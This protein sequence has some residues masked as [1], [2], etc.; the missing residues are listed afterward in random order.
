MA[1]K[2]LLVFVVFSSFMIY[3]EE[4]VQK[5]EVSFEQRQCIEDEYLAELLKTGK[6]AKE[7]LDRIKKTEL[8]ANK[9]ET[10]ILFNEALIDACSHNPKAIEELTKKNKDQCEQDTQRKKNQINNAKSG[11]IG[12]ENI[13]SESLS[14]CFLQY[15][16]ECKK[17]TDEIND[18]LKKIFDERRAIL[19]SKVMPTFKDQIVKRA[20]TLEET[21]L[22]GFERCKCY[23]KDRER[24]SACLSEDNIILS[25]ISKDDFFDKF[26]YVVFKRVIEAVQNEGIPLSEEQII[27]ICQQRI[28][29][30]EGRNYSMNDLEATKKKVVAA[31]HD[32]LNPNDEAKPSILNENEN[33]ENEEL[34][35][36]L[37]NNESEAENQD[38]ILAEVPIER[39]CS[40]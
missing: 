9:N 27:K 19:E 7:R 34:K 32:L 29:H 31:L 2:L 22:P 17:A 30:Y 20:Y 28:A 5:E 40:T 10:V 1:K 14:G 35:K 4:N 11:W 33:T 15:F 18:E 12:G 16:D 6:V 24:L 23:A 26:T 38:K 39:T 8:D 13:N 36:L 37:N 3:S 25:E 21:Y